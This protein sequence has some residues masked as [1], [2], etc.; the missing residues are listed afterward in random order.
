MQKYSKWKATY[1]HKCSQTGETPQPGPKGSGFEDDL[2]GICDLSGLSN[3]P[4]GNSQDPLPPDQ[5]AYQQPPNLPA[6]ST[7]HDTFSVPTQPAVSSPGSHLH[8]NPID[9]RRSTQIV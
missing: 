3:L 1:L 2:G 4:T 8:H 6:G 7:Q 9:F 5:S